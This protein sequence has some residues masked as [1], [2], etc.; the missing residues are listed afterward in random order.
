MSDDDRVPAWEP[1]A[2]LTGRLLL[3]GIFLHEAFV[4]LGNTAGAVRYAEAYGM[5]RAAIPVAIAVELGCG[6][7]VAFGLFTRAASLV[8]AMFCLATAAIFHTKLGETNQ[9]LHF[10]K[11][12]AIAG[13]FIVLAVHGAGRWSIDR[14]WRNPG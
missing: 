8:L 2:L 1:A 5:P 10:E 14:I 9:L 7:A 6:L 11:N 13:G 3:S 4:K 12:L